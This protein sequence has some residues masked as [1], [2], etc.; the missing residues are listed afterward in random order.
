MSFN[1]THLF[2]LRPTR[3][4]VSLYDVSEAYKLTRKMENPRQKA[5]LYLCYGL[6]M[7][8]VEN[9][10]PTIELLEKCWDIKFDLQKIS[11]ILP[12]EL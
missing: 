4:F 9:M 5:A 2:G 10:Y 7:E 3:G 6:D 8:R 11:Y 12:Q 1:C